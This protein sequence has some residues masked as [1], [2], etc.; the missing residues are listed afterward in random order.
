MGYI[1]RL[2]LP[3]AIPR[4]LLLTLAPNARV[5]TGQ[6]HKRGFASVRDG[7]HLVVK[8]TAPANGAP[9]AAALRVTQRLTRR[10]SPAAFR[11]G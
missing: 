6:G 8:I 1:T 9:G 11:L 10:R 2:S 4:R 5:N 3:P 7:R